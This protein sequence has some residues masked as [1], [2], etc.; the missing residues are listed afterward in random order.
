MTPFQRKLLNLLF[1]ILLFVMMAIALDR[2]VWQWLERA[3]PKR[4]MVVRVYLF[5]L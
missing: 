2:G 3:S 5:P 1:I 4:K